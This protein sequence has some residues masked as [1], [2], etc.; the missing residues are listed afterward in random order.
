M[1]VNVRVML[2]IIALTNSSVCV[3]FFCHGVARVSQFEM[4]NEVK[5]FDIL[6]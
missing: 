3:L 6:M 1:N 5:L 4:L 2:P